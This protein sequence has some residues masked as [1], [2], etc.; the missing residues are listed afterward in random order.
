M[1]RLSQIFV[2]QLLDIGK[3]ISEVI[4]AGLVPVSVQFLN[5]FDDPRLQDASATILTTIASGT[6]EQTHL[7]V[8]NGAIPPFIRLFGNPADFDFDFD[9]ELLSC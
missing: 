9:V 3:C 8:E 2:E 6:S 7:V 5:H 4:A 1:F